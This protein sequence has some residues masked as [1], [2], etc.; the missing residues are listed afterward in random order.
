MDKQWKT[1][2]LELRKRLNPGRLLVHE[3]WQIINVGLFGIIRMGCSRNRSRGRAEISVRCPV[4]VASSR[5]KS[6]GNMAAGSLHYDSNFRTVLSSLY[7]NY[8][9]LRPTIRE[10]TFAIYRVSGLHG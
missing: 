4:V 7:R 3:R 1:F 5:R 2:E 8:C 6:R 9:V 10:F